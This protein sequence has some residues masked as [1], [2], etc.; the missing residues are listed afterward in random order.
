MNEET[1]IDKII[2]EAKQEAENIVSETKQEIE[3]SISENLKSL[4]DYK[5]KILEEAREESTQ[6]KENEIS[7]A[8]LQA[9]NMI[10]EEK[11]KQIKLAK[12]KIEEKL[13]NLNGEEYVTFIKEII[14]KAN[15]E[16][17]LEIILPEKQK[18]QVIKA[19]NGK[20]KVSDETREFE[21]GFIVKKDNIEYNYV[22]DT[23][24][25]L[26]KEKVDK[27]LADILFS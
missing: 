17:G 11:Q 3:K 12:Q 16:N 18:E 22:L 21:S 5:E 15:F 25:D 27:I 23:I 24:L 8:E 1:I 26:E 4:D 2:S 7:V 13:L 14:E 19:L 6:I 20:F 9:R 10:L